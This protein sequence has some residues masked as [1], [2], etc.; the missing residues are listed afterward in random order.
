MSKIHM[1]IENSRKKFFEEAPKIHK[2]YY[3]Y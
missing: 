2:N 3:D 1:K